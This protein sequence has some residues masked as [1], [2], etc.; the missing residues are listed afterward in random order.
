M[1]NAS[2]KH[3]STG[4]VW[5]PAFNSLG[6]FG[7]LGVELL[8]CNSNLTFWGPAKQW[9]CLWPMYET[10]FGSQ[11]SG[12]FINLSKQTYEA[13]TVITIIFIQAQRGSGIWWVTHHIDGDLGLKTI[14]CDYSVHRGFLM[15]CD[16]LSASSFA[17]SPLLAWP[18][19][20]RI[21][22]MSDPFPDYQPQ[23]QGCVMII[24]LSYH[25]WYMIGSQENASWM[26]QWY[27]ASCLLPPVLHRVPGTEGCLVHGYWLNEFCSEWA[28]ECHC[29]SL[30]CAWVEKVSDGM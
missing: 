27:P 28:S 19:G 23:G 8:D 29:S 11:N 15:P 12:C 6:I 17:L 26:D 20:H 30:V 13:N 21:I 9:S 24:F 7:Y 25:V 22:D 1:N 10:P 14:L 5:V 18:L 16:T 3:W 4:S 2:C